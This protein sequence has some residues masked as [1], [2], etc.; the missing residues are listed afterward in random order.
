M[1]KRNK[2]FNQLMS[3]LDGIKKDL[4]EAYIFD[5]DMEGY[6]EMGGYDGMPQQGME[7]QPAQG[8]EGEESEE[9]K[10]LHAQEIA[11]HEPIIMKMR[12]IA[13]QGLQKYSDQPL[14]SLYEFFKSTFLSSDKVLTDT[15]GG[16]K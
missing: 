6:G 9:E 15:G 11:Q 3:E 13:L 10:A 1:I 8:D 12:E 5:E 7:G 14:S 4:N 16:K 2:T